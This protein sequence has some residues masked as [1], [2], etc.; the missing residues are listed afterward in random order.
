MTQALPQAAPQTARPNTVPSTSS[1]AASSCASDAFCASGSS[2]TVHLIGPGAVGRALLGLIDDSVFQLVGVT[3]STA[4]IHHKRGLDALAVAAWKAEGNPLSAYAHAEAIPVELAI[5]LVDADI[6]V[7][8]TPTDFANKDQA[9]ARGQ[10]VLKHP[11][12]LV[13]AAKD[14]LCAAAD[15]WLDLQ[16]AAQVGCNAVLGGTGLRLS[17]ELTELRSRWR[18]ITCAGNASTTTIIT[19]L[20]AGLSLAEGI[21]Q[22][23]AAGCLETDPELDLRGTDA[24][25][26]LAVVAGALTGTVYD[27]A[28][29]PCEDIRDLDPVLVRQRAERGLTT[30]LVGRIDRV[31]KP[32]VSYEEVDRCSPIAVPHDRVVYQY[33]LEDGSLRIHTGAGIG[34]LPTAKA[35]FEDLEAFAELAFRQHVAK[36]R[37]GGLVG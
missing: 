16:H 7:D 21:E 19:A 31:G 14:G 5:E 8:T 25:V 32:V 27:P 6:V 1:V 13:L 29:I 2:P 37:Q 30:R 24:A 15:S 20:E 35:V 9:I 3:D 10:A 34:H 12:H 11:A 22:A 17:R 23:R 18:S 4:T 36:A 33:E 28:A 26:K